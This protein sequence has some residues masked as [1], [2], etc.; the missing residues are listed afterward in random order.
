MKGGRR[1]R[2]VDRWQAPIWCPGGRWGPRR[3]RTSECRLRV[4]G[5]DVYTT[6]IRKAARGE[7]L[8]PGC[9]GTVTYKHAGRRIEARWEVR[10]NSIW[11]FG[12]VFFRCGR[13]SR[14]CS[15][16]YLPLDNLELGCRRCW[17]LSYPSRTLHNYKDSL[18]GRGQ[19]ARI[20]G[21]TQREWAN[22]NT[23]D[24]RVERRDA[25]AA[26]WRKRRRYLGKAARTMADVLVPIGS[27]A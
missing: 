9:C 22:M 24:R 13:C 17:G 4:R 10:P 11:R 27:R 14:L 16:L 26:R 25:A 3:V 8:G 21:T 15:R 2:Y 1:Q 5:E 18:W 20:L 19:L 6:L 23:N 12:R 7:R